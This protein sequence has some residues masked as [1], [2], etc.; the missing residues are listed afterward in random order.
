MPGSS[1]YAGYGCSYAI[2]ACA[3]TSLSAYLPFIEASGLSD[4]MGSAVLSIR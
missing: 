3:A 1:A 4:S 2:W